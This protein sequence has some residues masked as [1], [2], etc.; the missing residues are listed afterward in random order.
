M[1]LKFTLFLFTITQFSYCQNNDTID[2][3]GIEGPLKF[4]NTSF[5]LKWT[6]KPN[7]NYFIQEY[8]PKNENLKRFKQMLTYHLFITNLSIKEAAYQKIN[9]LHERKKID[10]ICNYQLLESD[11]GNSF[12]VDFIISEEK[13]GTVTIVEFNIYKFLK[14]NDIENKNGILVFAYTE[15]AYKSKMKPFLEQL[16]EKR[17]KKINQ[18]IDYN[19]SEINLK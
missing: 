4:N 7:E 16:T 8:I 2:R 14:I 10:A 1:N 17:N 18:V 13:R 9:E 11:D 19:M 3:I 6:D 12:I 5:E 15:R